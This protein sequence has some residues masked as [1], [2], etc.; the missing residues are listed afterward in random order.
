[1]PYE[2]TTD[3][4]YGGTTPTIRFLKSDPALKK[5]DLAQKTITFK[6]HRLIFEAD[7]EFEAKDLGRVVDGKDLAAKTGAKEIVAK[8]VSVS[9]DRPF[10]CIMD[11]VTPDS[12]HSDILR[13]SQQWQS[14][15]ASVEF[16]PTT[17]AAD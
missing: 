16:D 2:Q 10:V 11:Q 9:T 12:A 3:W 1:M 7:G 4:K 6:R 14:V 15:L 5:T 13:Q 17:I 8:L